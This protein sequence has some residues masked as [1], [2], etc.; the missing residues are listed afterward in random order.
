M[1]PNFVIIGAQK[2]GTSF[3]VRCLKEHP[4]VFL[5]VS[6]TRFFEDPDYL[7]SDIKQLYHPFRYVSQEKAV[8][9]KRP[10]YLARPECPARI[11]KH[12]PD[13]KLVAILRNPVE[14]AIAGYY[15]EMK[16]G[17]IPMMSLED[18]MAK[19]L[20]GAYTDS[21][22]IAQDIINFGFYHRHLTRYLEFFDKDQI[23]VQLF[24][25]LKANP[26]ESIRQVYRFLCV[27]ERFVP[28]ALA[29][30][31]Q[32]NPGVYSLTRIRWLSLRNPFMY[33]YYHHRTRRHRKQ[34]TPLNRL[35]NR[36]ITEIDGK[37]LA[38]LCDNSKPN[39]SPDL[40][41]RLFTTYAEDINRLEDFLGRELQSWRIQALEGK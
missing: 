21:H 34:P 27:D 7:H 39:P 33:T 17:F 25:D 6:E 11:F 28:T 16:C 9:I 4:D 1:L 38:R 26:L 14:R 3:M 22:P 12:L 40:R 37:L 23:L 35:I 19:V 29:V 31:S 30:K 13:A 41:A 20:S 15:H 8:G 10:S 18:G 36:G 32:R 24:D 5:P 2:A